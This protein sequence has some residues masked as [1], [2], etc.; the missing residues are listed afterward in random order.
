MRTA[1]LDP[2][3]IVRRHVL[4]PLLVLVAAGA[5]AW[6]Q[7]TPGATP[8][9]TEVR[10]LFDA[11]CVLCHG[12]DAPTLGLDLSSL[13]GALAGSDRG[14]VIVPG[15]P[16]VSELVLRVRGD[17]QPRMPLTGPPWLSDDQI[18]LLTAW[19]AG[20]APV[21]VPP[22][23]A[24]APT[25]SEEAVAPTPPAAG[26]PMPDAASGSFADVDRI[27]SSRC[28]YC[29]TAGGAMGPAPE[30]LVLTTHEA[31]LAGGDRV[32]I[33]PGLPLASELYRRVIGLGVP[34]MPFD[35]PPWLDDADVASLRQWI[36]DGAP[37]AD[38]TPSP[39]PVG[40]DV[41][42]EGTLT[43]RWELDGLPFDVGRDT[44]IEDAPAL[45]DRIEVR[46]VVAPDGS[47]RATRI[48]AR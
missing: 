20:G 35:G 16:D 23:S 39:V 30:G 45:G 5:P 28:A 15:D 26:P 37:A 3:R 21:E 1:R 6:A 9:P 43:A 40:G 10:A 46:G 24:G 47:I 48:R 31:R 33:V 34:R 38:G 36:E 2:C 41:R 32:V 7:P 22:A 4:A 42:F 8:D 27:L 17:R 19:V 13:E 29:H 14:P 18:A 11:H 44:R 12:D 25:P